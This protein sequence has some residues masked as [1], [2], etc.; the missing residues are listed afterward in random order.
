MVVDERKMI[1]ISVNDLFIEGWNL[2]KV[3]SVNSDMFQ[4]GKYCWETGNYPA[5]G[6]VDKSFFF[7]PK[8]SK[9]PRMRCNCQNIH[10]GDYENMIIDWNPWRNRTCSL[11]T[12]IYAEIKYLWFLGIE[13]IGSCCGHN[14]T[15]GVITVAHECISQMEMLGYERNPH[16]QRY[17]NFFYPKSIRVKE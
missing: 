10:F 1:Y 14:I 6:I 11:D 7:N 16:L 17:K 2:Y 12:C 5:I 9:I 4:L 13:T 15:Y 3:L 8:I